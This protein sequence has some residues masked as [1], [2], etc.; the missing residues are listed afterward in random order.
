MDRSRLERFVNQRLADLPLAEP[1]FVS[2]SDPV[3]HAVGLMQRGGPSAVLAM[4]G[5]E[6]A[7]IFTERDV[8]TKCMVDG[9]DWGQPLGDN[10]LTREPRVIS[11]HA[12][13]GDAIALMQQGNYRTLPVVDE[14]RVRGLIRLGDL[15]RQLAEVYPEDVLNL[16]PR[17]HQVIPKREGG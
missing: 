3:R 16:P 10:V 14:G 15:M 17:P 1:V 2:P 7:G 6:L 11:S 4:E 8:L 5:T 13:V 12:T 9:F